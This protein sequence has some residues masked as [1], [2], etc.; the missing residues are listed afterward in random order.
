M[1]PAW[2][3][4]YVVANHEKR[5]SK[6]LAAHNVDHYLPVYGEQSHWSD[7]TIRIERPLFPGYVFVRFTPE[8]RRLVLRAPGV[9]GLT[10]ERNKL[11]T[12]PDTDIERLREAVAG[13]H[14]P[15]IPLQWDCS[16]LC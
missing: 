3:A 11:G 9:V 12:I 2:S 4:L 8:Q 15:Q 5:V 13:G 10:G 7:R 1:Q 6:F 14:R 16:G